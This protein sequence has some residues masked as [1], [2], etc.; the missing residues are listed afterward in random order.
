MQLFIVSPL[1]L[2]PL[3]WYRRKMMRIC[4]PVVI[5]GATIVSILVHYFVLTQ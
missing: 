4:L 1:V 3:L 5:V 2:F